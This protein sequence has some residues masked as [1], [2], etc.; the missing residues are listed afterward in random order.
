MKEQFKQTCCTAAQN[1]ASQSTRVFVLKYIETNLTNNLNKNKR[2]KMVFEWRLR[3]A[4]N[5]K[6]KLLLCILHI[7]FAFFDPNEK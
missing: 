7:F 2:I 4:T 1:A 6:V 5:N 3:S